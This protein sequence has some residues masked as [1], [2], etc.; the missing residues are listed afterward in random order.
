MARMR[1]RKALAVKEH[2][3]LLVES[4]RAHLLPF[5]LE[6]GFVIP[7]KVRR[8]PTDRECDLAFPLG[9]FVRARGTGVDVIEIQFAPYRRAAFRVTAGVAPEDGITTAMGHCAAEEVCVQWLDEFFELY[10][11]PRW[12]TWFSLGCSWF[13]RPTQGD[14]ANLALTVAR[15]L[16]EVESALREGHLGPHMR[17]VLIPRGAT[18]VS[19][20]GNG[21]SR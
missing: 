15:L 1:R 16:P 8:A 7:P 21:L 4:L 5:L 18:Q 9:Q 6:Q 3:E 2:R 12:R 14:Y 19:P 20:H 17:R 11:R 10:A 13:R